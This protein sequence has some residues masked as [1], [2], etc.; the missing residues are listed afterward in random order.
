MPARPS[1][2]RN[3]PA[4]TSWGRSFADRAA[5]WT[6]TGGGIAIIASIL[7]ILVFIAAEVVPLFRSASVASTGP[8]KSVGAFPLDVVADEYATLWAALCA[9]GKVR[10]APF[11]SEESPSELPI[12]AAG[13][14]PLRRAIP[15]AFGRVFTATTLDGRL[16]VVPVRFEVTYVKDDRR[17]RLV[18]GK[19]SLVEL[20]EG[21]A[22][23]SEAAAAFEEGGAG[24]VA[25]RT[26][27]GAIRILRR[28]V[29]VNP[30]TEEADDS[31]SRA[32]LRAPGGVS[33]LAVDHEG[34]NLFGG[35]RDGRLAW[36]D[37]THGADREPQVVT[38][39]GSPVTVLVLL[40]GDRSLLV[41]Q[42]D[43]T[44][45][46]WFPVRN[47]DGTETL[48]FVRRF[49]NQTS[50]IKI[51]T[52]G[53][54]NKCFVAC[55]ASGGL[56]LYHSTAGRVL[57][58]GS[59][60]LREVS[61]VRF[62]P[63]GDGL[64]LAGSDGIE[65]LRIDAP[66]PEFSLQ[67]IF[68]PVW[69]EDRPGPEYTWQSTGG[70][71]D[72]EPKL[73]LT[74][75]L[76]G[77]L[78][79]TFYS[80]ILAIPIAILAA[81]YTSQFMHTSLRRFVKPV[82]EIMA[83]LPSVVLGFIA[84][85]WLAPRLERHFSVV[86]LTTV[87]FP[88]SILAA[89][90]ASRLLPRGFRSRLPDGSAAFAF[91]GV[92]A[93]ALGAALLLDEPFEAWAFG[94]NFPAW[95]LE[96]T[97]LRYDQRNAIVVGLAMGFAVVPIIFAI[98]E[99]AFSNVPP[100]LVSASLALGANRWQTVTRVVLPTASPG[101]FSATM[102]GFGRVVGETMIVLMA[103]GNTPIMT[104]NPFDGFRTLSA[105]IAYEISEAVPGSTHYRTLFLAALLLFCVTFVVNTVADVV[106]Q[107]LRSKYSSL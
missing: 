56:G 11:E 94:G 17:V 7:G 49:P 35:T 69:Y 5:V 77:T 107:R 16:L 85:L 39:S 57:W 102:V 55:D 97:K 23:V 2:P 29:E 91:A 99:D 105:N 70:T 13:A 33:A 65:S 30:M 31:W 98:A 87:L 51:L 12:S 21:S 68:G 93:L 82:V 44:I 4:G 3:A 78:K 19:G 6:V 100:G 1:G 58:K 20:G 22:D 71:D 72:H 95:L 101:V 59:T 8:A 54:R 18:L 104:A 62:L 14:V 96:T 52:P 48:T 80:L 37:L 9:D 66:H 73:S 67:T 92:L 75:L 90:F 86:L 47:P 61:A 34:R 32:E 106:R 36:W 74:P 89:G 40:L 64:L 43:G 53:T 88:A 60:R 24:L 50:E 81:I 27:G 83:A 28:T 25:W 41:G 63:K 15:V 38:V 103:A 46:V 76:V 79:A 84:G 42:A 45:S 10:F 26:S